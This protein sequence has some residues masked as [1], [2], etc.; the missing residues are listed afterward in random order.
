MEKGEHHTV[1][2]A[3]IEDVIVDSELNSEN[4]SDGHSYDHRPDEVV[5]ETAGP[6]VASV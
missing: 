3:K 6:E 1:Y 5:V 2:T 4:T